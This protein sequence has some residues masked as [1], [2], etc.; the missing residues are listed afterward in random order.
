MEVTSQFVGAPFRDRSM[1]ITTRQAMNFAASVFD[2]NPHFFDDEREGGIVAHPMLACAITWQSSKDIGEYLIADDFPAHLT[3]F[4]VH[5]T[6]SI[7]WHRPIRPGDVLTVHG[8]LSAIIPHRAG[9]HSVVRYDAV[10]QHGEPVFTEFTGAMLR[11][12]KCVDEG[13]GEDKV[14]PLPRYRSSEVLWEAPINLHPLAAHIYDGCADISFPI[15]SSV[16]FAHAVGLP[17]III[18]GTATVSYAVSELIRREADGDPS[19]VQALDC[20]FTGMVMP[21]SSIAVKLK[22][23]EADG[24][25]TDLY[26]DVVDHK[27]RRV[28]TNCR[29]RIRN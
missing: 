11:D 15:H 14:P 21:G 10:D 12:V 26:W 20:R 17:D 23:R 4:Q 29:L 27:D 25:F 28:V 3:R 16:A 13:S 18:Q 19:R 8:E 1:E 5:Y 24:D 9:T 7:V 6:E 2:D 22:G